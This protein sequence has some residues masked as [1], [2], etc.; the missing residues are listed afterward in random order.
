MQH[1][2][3][4]I[5]DSA[6]DMTVNPIPLKIF[7]DE[8]TMGNVFP[9]LQQLAFNNKQKEKATITAT[10]CQEHTSQPQ[11]NYYNSNYRWIVARKYQDTDPPLIPI[12]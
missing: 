8:K 12:T 2:Q 11:N 9:H 3:H 7:T 6:T 5:T 4:R 10:G 1:I